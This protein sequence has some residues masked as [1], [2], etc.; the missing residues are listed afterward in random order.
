MSHWYQQDGQAKHRIVGANGAERD[1]TLRDARTSH[2]APSVTT[3]ISEL[4]SPGLTDWMAME[5]IKQALFEAPMLPDNLE[6]SAIRGIFSR[7]REATKAKA[8]LG[9]T[10]HKAVERALRDDA[11]SIEHAKEI[12][13]TLTWLESLSRALWEPEVSFSHPLGYGGTTDAVCRNDKIVVDFKTKEFRDGDDVAVY[14]YHVMQLAACAV[15]VG[16]AK[17]EW[18]CREWDES[19]IKAFNL[20]ISTTTPGFTVPIPWTPKAMHRGFAMFVSC[21]DLW[22]ARNKYA[23][24]WSVPLNAIRL[25]G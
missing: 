16:I 18:T 24:A 17:A 9:T 1:T 19:G 15:G 13:A 22:Q 2:L 3:I 8:A 10:I 5:A 25:K 21:L 14:D 12:A 20:F 6:P 4:A 23:P 11:I 7:S